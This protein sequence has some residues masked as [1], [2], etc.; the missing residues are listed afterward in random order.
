VIKTVCPLKEEP[1]KC[2]WID[3]KCPREPEPTKCPEKSTECPEKT[4]ECPHKPTECPPTPT[5]CH[6]YTHCDVTH[7]PDAPT[8]CEYAPTIC[9]AFTWC[10]TVPGECPP[11]SGDSHSDIGRVRS[12]QG[13]AVY[14]MSRMGVHGPTLFQNNPN[15]FGRETTITYIIPA[16]THVTIRVYDVTGRAVRT[17]V[18]T[19]KASGLYNETLD[20]TGLDNG[21]YFYRMV[22][23]GRVF[24]GKATLVR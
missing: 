16:T 7:K 19:E 18:D 3:T 4:T 21:V 24:T 1:T 15:P 10:P 2:P 20:G 17:L 13:P 6:V 23:D 22:A 9:R 14:S 5:E 8:E 12:A 11:D